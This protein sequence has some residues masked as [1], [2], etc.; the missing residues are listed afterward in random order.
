M[1]FL[2]HSSDLLEFLHKSINLVENIK[3]LYKEQFQRRMT[4]TFHF[5]LSAPTHA[6]VISQKH[7]TIVQHKSCYLETMKPVSVSCWIKSFSF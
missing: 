5:D 4:L 3:T 6:R 7:P 1:T 2:L